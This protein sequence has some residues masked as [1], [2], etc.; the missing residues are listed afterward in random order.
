MY[1]L[2]CT[3]SRCSYCKKFILSC[4][5][6]AVFGGCVKLLLWKC[7]SRW[8]FLFDTC[9]STYIWLGYAM[10]DCIYLELVWFYWWFWLTALVDGL[11]DW[12]MGMFLHSFL[13]SWIHL[14]IHS[15]V[16]F[17]H[18][19][20]HSFFECMHDHACIYS[21]SL[22]SSVFSYYITLLPVSQ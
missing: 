16:L 4:V 8:L 9:R 5:A 17:P 1:L 15:C 21:V 12:V 11:I 22:A 10:F 2:K 18:W 13:H 6:S 3:H 14:F 20:L 7:C 19:F